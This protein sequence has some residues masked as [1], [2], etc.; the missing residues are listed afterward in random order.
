MPGSGLP[1]RARAPR[2][3]HGLAGAAIVL[4]QESAF[5]G[6][7]LGG[8][9]LDST[10]WKSLGL[11]LPFTK[12]TALFSFAGLNQSCGWPQTVSLKKSNEY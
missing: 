8:R 3:Q 2:G 12:K 6:V 7:Q 1:A 9:A 10:Q 4:G 11:G 5:L